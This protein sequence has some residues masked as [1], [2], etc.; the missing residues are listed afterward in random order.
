M[1]P[2]TYLITASVAGASAS[3]GAMGTFD[4][5][6]HTLAKDGMYVCV[7]MCVVFTVFLSVLCVL[8][9]ACFVFSVH[10]IHAYEYASP[11]TALKLMP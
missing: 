8:Y 1:G 5:L 4:R 2:C 10:S 9:S 3:G 6:K 7:C 11:Y